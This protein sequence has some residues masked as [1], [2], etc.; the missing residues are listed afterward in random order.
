M[1]SRPT[2]ICL[3]LKIGALLTA[4]DM[5]AAQLASAIGKPGVASFVYWPNAIIQAFLPCVPMDV[6]GKHYCEGTPLNVIAFWTSI[7]VSVVLYAV[8]A[9]IVMRHQHG[10]RK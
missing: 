3:S 7:P 8:I 9:F 10:Q 5:G 6:S 4:L 1:R 2:P